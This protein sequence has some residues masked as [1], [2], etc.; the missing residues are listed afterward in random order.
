MTFRDYSIEPLPIGKVKIKDQFWAAKIKTNNEI[1]IPYVLKKCEETG[2]IDNF[3]RAARLLKGDQRTIFPF[4]DSD[5]YKAIE[6]AAYS[7]IHQ[8]NDELEKYIDDFVEKLAMAQEEDGYIYTNRTINPENPHVWAGNNRWEFVQIMSHEIYCIGH[9]IESAV[10][11]YQATGKKKYLEL[12]IKS[13]DLLDRTFGIGKNESVPG[14]QEIELALVRLYRITGN[15]KYLNLAKFFLDIRGDKNAK[16]YND[17]LIKAETLPGPNISRK[18]EY[19]QTHK[20]P[21][22]QDEAVGHAVRA[23]YMYSAMTDIAALTDDRNYLQAVDKIWD[24][25]VSKKLSITGGVGAKTLGESF[26]K[27][28]KLPNLKV[29]NETCASIGNVF[30][31]HRL[32][33]L[34]GDAKYIDV[35]ER[36]LYNGLIS[37]ISFDGKTFFYPNPLASKGY[38]S[39]SPWFEVPCCPTNI[40]RFLSSIPNYIY[41]QHHKLIYVNLFVSSTASILMN[42][43]SI[44]ISQETEYPWNGNVTIT[45]NL[46]GSEE[47]SIAI[48]IPGWTQNRPVPSDLYQYVKE[49]NTV[50]SIKVNDEPININQQKG[51]V[52]INRIW[53]DGD[54]IEIDMPMPIRRVIAHENVKNNNGRV[55]LERGP[56]VY[57]LER[58]DNNVENIFNLYLDD[59]DCLESDYKNNLFEGIVVISGNIHYLKKTNNHIEKSETKFLAIPYY[60]W[61]NRGK[62]DMTI[63]MLRDLKAFQKPL[64]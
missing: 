42:Q 5:V 49:M 47:F 22:E 4:D 25:V 7:L 16:G 36:I 56:L 13:A 33:L 18:L 2:R 39:R 30:W 32:F 52:H 35:L 12:A 54:K 20:Q 1:T 51:Y 34:H 17:Y 63:W 46:E 58:H 8:K 62:G 48:R 60:V 14:H 61:A 21:I 6:S 50:V 19:N 29:Y 31:N 41:A 43:K 40:A 59:N 55:A 45:I 23:M 44:K 10:T 38:N 27:N 26:G 53:S 24:N 11:Y 3:L 28:Y 64:G 57:C 9:L 15:K 37:G